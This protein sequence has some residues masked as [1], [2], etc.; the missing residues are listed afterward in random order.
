M[1]TTDGA[2]S[3]SARLRLQFVDYRI[4][5]ETNSLRLAARLQTYFKDYLAGV[6]AAAASQ[7]LRAIV[8]AAEYDATRLA[9]WGQRCIA[10]RFGS[11]RSPSGARRDC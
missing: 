5:V 8:G 7:R 6:N 11:P 2:F 1:T 4:D 9:V 10:R 3:V